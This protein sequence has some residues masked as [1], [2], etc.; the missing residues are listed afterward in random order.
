MAIQATQMMMKRTKA[1]QTHYSKSKI[2]KKMEV[3]KTGQMMT[4]M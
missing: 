3:K 4:E 1:I 2:K